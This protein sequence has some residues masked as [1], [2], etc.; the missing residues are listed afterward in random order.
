MRASYRISFLSKTSSL[1]LPMPALT[2]RLSLGLAL[3]ITLLAGAVRPQAAPLPEDGRILRGKLENGVTWMYRQHNN[4]PGKMALQ[5]H[6]RTGS[7][8]ETD[9]QRGLAH[10]LEHMAFNGTE[11]FPPGK[12][13]PYFESIGMQF[14]AH[15]NAYTS[16]DQTVYMLFTPNTE[17]E[18]IDKALLVLSD[19]IFRMSLLEGEIDK[20]R[21]VVLEE[22]R[23][24][25]SA[26]ERIR[27]KLWP[28]LFEG[29]RF[30]DRLPIG[31]D[32]ILRSAPPQEFSD[33]YRHWYRPENVTVMLVGDAPPEGILPLIK[34]RFG[35]YKPETSPRAPKGPEFK[36]FTKERA[37][38]VTDPESAYCQVQLLNIRPGRPP[39]VTSEQARVD[40]VEG[41]GAWIMGRRYDQRVKKGEAS[42]R[43]AGT[44][45]GNFFN[46]AMLAQGFAIGEPQD[47]GKM[48]DEVIVEI[49]RAAKFGFTENEMNLARREILADA[50]RAVRTE[51]TQNAQAIVG[52]MT[53][54]T[55]EREPIRS[56]QQKLDLT[57]ELLPGIRAEEVS[58]A[59][60]AHFARGTFAYILTM[61]DK[62]GVTVPSRQ[63]V[64]ARAQA[65]AALEPAK[66]ADQSTR[67]NILA[68]LPEPAAILEQSVDKDLSIT[69]AWLE[70]G[71]RVHHRF[72][73]YKKDSVLVSIALA[74]GNI[75]ETAANAGITTVAT[76]AVDEAAT[77]EISSTEM[78][79]LMTGKNIEVGASP[80]GD[81]LLL[82]VTGSPLDLEAGL[83]QAHALLMDGK[84]EEAAFK[85][86]RLL[87]LQQ[88]DER[89][90]LPQF[91]A[92]EALED[93]LSGGDPRRV[94]LSRKRVEEM[95]L[96]DAQAWFQRICRTG[97]IEVAVVG[98]IALEKAL[99]LIQRYVGSL[100][101]RDRRSAR[102]D[103][104]R[105]SPR[106]AG[107][108]ERH[109]KVE[110]VTPQA[111]ALA[112]FASAQGKDT[113]DARALELASLTLTSRLIKQIREELSIVYS[114][115]ASHSPSWIYEDAGRIVAGAP[116]DPNNAE[117]VVREAHQ[118]FA[119]FAKDGPTEEELA[120]AKKQIANSLDTG[121][122]EPGYWW[123]ILRNMELKNR[124]LAVEKTIK[125][126]Y[127]KY[128]VEQIKTIFNKY[129]KPERQFQV[130]AVPVAPKTAE[131]K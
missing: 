16:F 48:L 112:G 92:Q 9:S 109:V 70:N 54:R 124:N 49:S 65:A 24:G 42:F 36:S 19:Y 105:R 82:T 22:S 115:R 38:V 27:D 125:D 68:K 13:I 131:T 59:F 113:V 74:G 110:T 122:R 88:M 29:S 75:E 35:E 18:Q 1:R 7:L 5:V 10:F 44:F 99:P 118:I 84:I 11:N 32:E 81:N 39:T 47:W 127:Q 80:A 100:P 114:I 120:N 98:D 33:Y 25:K 130:T 43:M 95:S 76:L 60:T 72:M 91:K 6:V 57:R 119:A 116:C 4:P 2:A 55:N 104:L 15:L 102:I 108:L 126:D 58:A 12:L 62:P 77:S 64:L 67:T 107:P 21:G 103:A 123:G 50:E 66:L 87:T 93:L 28:E 69:S 78:R 79:D 8:N 37:L 89:E 14:G 90:K 45:V 106:P 51:P 97:P 63:E 94:P 83:Q 111:V 128:T 23:S 53:A 121:M 31:K 117:K 52:E 101:K 96:P 3:A 40:L 71:T 61:M 85:N 46:D 129:Y 20:E 41:I 26:E 73:D 56:A 86:W 34:K 30:A 17:L